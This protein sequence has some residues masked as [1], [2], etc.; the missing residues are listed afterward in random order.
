MTDL[1]EPLLATPAERPVLVYDGDCGFCTYW[2]RRWQQKAKD[3]F[4]IV[5]LQDEE[6]R[7]GGLNTAEL[8]EAV[9]LVEPDGTIRRGADA[10][11]EVMASLRLYRVGRW[12]YQKIPPFRWVSDWLYRWVAN[13]RVLVSR[14]TR[15]MR[16]RET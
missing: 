6:G 9:H 16:R 8:E 5:P 15:W 11:F 3:S 12:A 1:D 10:V 13:H 4:A 7:P 2:A 14:W